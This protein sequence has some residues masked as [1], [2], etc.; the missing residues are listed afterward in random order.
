M[1]EKKIINN[2]SKSRRGFL[3]DLTKWIGGTALLAATANVFSSNKVKADTTSTNSSDPFIGEIIMFAG[4]FAPRNWAFC[5][6]QLLQISSFSALFSI[7]G[8]TY[9]GNG[10]STFGLP[11]LR[12]RVPIHSG[13]SQGPGLNN[14]PLGSKSGNENHTLTVNQMPS[15]NHGGSM[16]VNSEAGTTDTPSNGYL[17]TNSE[18]VKHYSSSQNASTGDQ[19]I[20]LQGGGQQFNIMQP[21]L[22]VNFIIAINGTFPS[23]S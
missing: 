9:G 10:E 5:N 16:K 3:G 8:T 4:N 13:N 12:G 6:G 20:P 22:A 15:H 19:S 23:P 21:F 14:R 17:A 2:D 1:S 11:D 7:L 18:G